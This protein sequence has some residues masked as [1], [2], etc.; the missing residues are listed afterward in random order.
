MFTIYQIQIQRYIQIDRYIKF[1]VIKQPK[2]TLIKK[3]IYQIIIINKLCIYK[4][5]LT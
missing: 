1:I 5:R 2:M 3:S 4:T